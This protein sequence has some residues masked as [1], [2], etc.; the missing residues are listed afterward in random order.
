MV[1]A[2]QTD[3]VALK[4]PTYAALAVFTVV[5]QIIGYLGEGVQF[6]WSVRGW[7]RHEK[8]RK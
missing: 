8:H 6:C 5:P 4:Q 1:A 3:A 2:Y 7:R